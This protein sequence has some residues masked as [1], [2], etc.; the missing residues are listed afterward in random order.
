MSGSA[1]PSFG[2]S[3]F[4]CADRAAADTEFRAGPRPICRS[5]HRES[6][7]AR[8]PAR[9]VRSDSRSKAPEKRWLLRMRL[10]ARC[11]RTPPPA[12]R[13]WRATPR[14]APDIPRWAG[15]TAPCAA[16]ERKCPP[17]A[18]TQIRAQKRSFFAVRSTGRF[19]ARVPQKC[20]LIVTL[21][22]RRF[23]R[24]CRRGYLGGSLRFRAAKA[25]PPQIG[26]PERHQA[27]VQIAPHEKKQERSGRVVLIL[28]GVQNAGRKIQSEQHFRI[29]HP[30]RALV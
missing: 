13:L 20:F 17:R 8:R 18:S 25:Q 1:G 7:A 4:S 5:R 27:G 3:H 6:A 21:D 10:R 24:S 19:H 16:T 11:S 29:R 2:P 12:R 30:A 23:A 9:H 14:V 26:L 22:S 28:N 15:E